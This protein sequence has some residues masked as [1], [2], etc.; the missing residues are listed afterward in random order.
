MLLVGDF[1]D[2]DNSIERYFQSQDYNV[3]GK[4]NTFPNFLPLL[5]PDKVFA[6]NLYIKSSIVLKDK[7]LIRLSDHLPIVSEL[8]IRKP[9]QV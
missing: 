8:A 2:F 9:I 4:Q 7:S 1:N 3:I 5:S 6:K